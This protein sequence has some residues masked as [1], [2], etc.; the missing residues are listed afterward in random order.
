MS[1]VPVWSWVIA[2][3]MRTRSSFGFSCLDIGSFSLSSVNI[4]SHLV[5]KNRL[6]TTVNPP[7]FSHNNENALGLVTNKKNA[8]TVDQTVRANWEG[9]KTSYFF[10]ISLLWS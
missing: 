7:L 2:I 1:D 4:P 3:A 6:V 8:P 9:F 5:L 10:V